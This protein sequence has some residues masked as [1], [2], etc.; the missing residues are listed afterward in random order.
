MKYPKLFAMKLLDFFDDY[1]NLQGGIIAIKN[2]VNKK[3]LDILKKQFHNNKI[4]KNHYDIEKMKI[5][6]E[7]LN[8][9]LKKN[10]G[11]YMFSLFE[12]MQKK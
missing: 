1:A 11:K 10:V 3:T 12:Q 7:K 9:V 2:V 4:G 5:A 8:S 6:E